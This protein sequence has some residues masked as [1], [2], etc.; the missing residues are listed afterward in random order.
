MVIDFNFRFSTAS[1]HEELK[2]RVHAI[3]DK[4]NLHYDLKWALS[5]LPFLTPRGT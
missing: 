1:T 2:R 3:L 5:G 4:H